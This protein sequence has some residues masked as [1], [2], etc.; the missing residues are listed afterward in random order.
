MNKKEVN[1]IKKNFSKEGELLTFHNIFTMFR[2]S[3]STYTYDVK[4]S[5]SMSEAELHL[6]TSTLKKV[7]NSNI[8]KSLVEYKFPNDAYSSDGVQTLLYQLNV[9][10]M[11]NEVLISKYAQHIADTYVSSEPYA[12]ITAHCIYTVYHKNSSG[13]VDK[14]S[15][16]NYN[17]II[18]AICPA[19]ETEDG[20]IFDGDTNSIHRAENKKLLISKSPVNGFI[21]P[22]FSD[23]SADINHIMSYVKNPNKPNTSFVTDTLGC[24]Y[25]MSPREEKLLFSNIISEIV[26]DEL[27][28]S[29]IKHIDTYIR[30]YI[31]ENKHNT[32]CTVIELPQII[33][34]LE[35]GNVSDE[36]LSHIRD[37]CEANFENL[38][39]VRFVAYNL[40]ENKLKINSLGLNIICSPD[41]D[42]IIDINSGHAPNVNVKL[43]EPD[44]TVSGIRVGR[45]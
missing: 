19:H 16:E 9:D 27:N 37:I 7:L 26:G 8:G 28:F 13:E 45:E 6:Y 18:T 1:E 20:F 5:Y 29:L 35:T 41:I 11:N 44:I 36:R 12:V 38:G 34:M 40:V 4:S 43:V 39:K 25:L 17:F 42:T 14:W 32:E 2:K 3:D 23:R 10:R 33:E 15:D 24:E 30:E 22:T 31:N 21:F